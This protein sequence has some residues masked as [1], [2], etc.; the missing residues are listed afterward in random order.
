M[1]L[2]AVRIFV[3]NWESACHFYGEVLGLPERFRND[4][5]GWAEYDLNGP[6]LGI[7]RVLPGDTEGEA[8][9]G[10]FL[11]VSLKVDNIE[12]TWGTLSKKGVAFTAPPEKQEWGGSLAQF[13]DPDGNILT[14]LG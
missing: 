13:Q 6:C 1:E 5:L 3:R 8:L 2:Y 4:E 10:R 9:V 14:L 11:G 12:K 7:E